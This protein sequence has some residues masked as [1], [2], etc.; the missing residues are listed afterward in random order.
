MPTSEDVST[1][2]P[3]GEEPPRPGKPGWYWDPWELANNVALRDRWRREVVIT[4]PASY[5]LRRWDG[6]AW[7]AETLRDYQLSDRGPLPHTCGPSSRIHPLTPERAG[8]NLRIWAALMALS[9]L[10]F[11]VSRGWS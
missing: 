2:R 7:T 6:D 11:V 10:A 4:G 3:A 1:L 5:L 9:V 8:R